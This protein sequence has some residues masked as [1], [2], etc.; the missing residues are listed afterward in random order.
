VAKAIAWHDGDYSKVDWSKKKQGN[1]RPEPDADHWESSRGT[2]FSFWGLAEVLLAEQWAKAE[3]KTDVEQRA[4]T[5]RLNWV[6]AIPADA[7]EDHTHIKWLPVVPD[8]FEG[9]VLGSGAPLAEAAMM[10]PPVE[11]DPIEEDR[12]DHGL[13]YP[14]AA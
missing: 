9:A 3:G 13:I 8:P 10:A 12:I 1:A 6:N 2:A 4:R 14:D 11:T 5:I 7:F